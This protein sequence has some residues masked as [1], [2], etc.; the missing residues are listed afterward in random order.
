MAATSYRLYKDGW[1]E[2]ED[3]RPFFYDAPKDLFRYSDGTFAFDRYHC[4][5]EEMKRRGDWEGPT[6]EEVS[7]PPFDL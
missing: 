3:I 4:D 6:P 7:R 2:G 5:V 1:N